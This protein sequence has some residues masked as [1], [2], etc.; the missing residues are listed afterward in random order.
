MSFIISFSFS[1]LFL[2]Q[3]IIA[4]VY[5]CAARPYIRRLHISSSKL[6][7]FAAIIFGDGTILVQTRATTAAGRRDCLP[8]CLPVLRLRPIRLTLHSYSR[9][10]LTC[11][12]QVYCPAFSSL[13]TSRTSSIIPWAP[14]PSGARTELTVARMTRQLVQLS[15]HIVWAHFVDA[16]LIFSWETCLAAGSPCGWQW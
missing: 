10:R 1:T 15:L 3:K 2:R 16:F 6:D 13:K 5:Q 8:R 14:V 4:T 9:N 12:S 11:R 7:C